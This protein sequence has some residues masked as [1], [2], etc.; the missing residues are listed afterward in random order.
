MLLSKI[1][2]FQQIRKCRHIF[3]INTDVDQM[4]G[5]EDGC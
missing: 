5:E 4:G 1:Q 3:A 2:Q